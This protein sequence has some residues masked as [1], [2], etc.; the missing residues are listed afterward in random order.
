MREAIAWSHDLL[1]D[2]EQVLFRRLGVFWRLHAGGGT[3]VRD[4]ALTRAASTSAR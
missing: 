4:W 3:R 1:T 2:P